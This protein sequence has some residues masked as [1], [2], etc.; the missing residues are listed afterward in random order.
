MFILFNET[1]FIFAENVN[2]QNPHIFNKT[3]S[4]P[5][6]SLAA[7]DTIL[8]PYESLF[9]LGR[10]LFLLLIDSIS[11]ILENCKTRGKKAN[12]SQS[13]KNANFPSF[14]H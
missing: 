5:L 10:F 2:T 1:L 4:M 7:R 11:M 12:V 6:H 3:H 9:R 14:K 13:K 8:D